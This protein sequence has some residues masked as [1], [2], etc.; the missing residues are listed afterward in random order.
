MTS[1]AISMTLELDNIDQEIKRLNG[2]IFKL[3]KR[4]KELYEKMKIYLNEK[5]TKAVKYKNINIVMEEKLK[6][7]KK[8]KEDKLKDC[9]DFLIKHNIPTSDKNILDFMKVM[10]GQEETKTTIKLKKIEN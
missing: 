3:R 7:T 1:E 9:K 2:Q 10:K 6:T 5:E 8:N 4:Q